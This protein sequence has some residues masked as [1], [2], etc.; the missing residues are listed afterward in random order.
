[1]PHQRRSHQPRRHR[2][3]SER[4]PSDFPE[5]HPRARND[6]DFPLRARSVGAARA[7]GTPPA[8]GSGRGIR[9]PTLRVRG[10]RAS[11]RLSQAEPPRA[12][13]VHVRSPHLPPNRASPA[14]RS[15]S[16]AP[17]DAGRDRNRRN[18]VASR[19]RRVS[20]ASRRQLAR[21]AAPVPKPRPSRRRA[22]TSV[23]APPRRRH[24]ARGARG[25]EPPR[26]S[27]RGA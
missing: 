21:T 5:S 17:R 9:H 7:A 13:R 14:A 20:R 25:S 10:R 16:S 11:P 4:R 3:F 2:F 8:R 23:G 22:S 1:M 6:F 15:A 26:S 18:R 19:R 24:R 27:P 12:A